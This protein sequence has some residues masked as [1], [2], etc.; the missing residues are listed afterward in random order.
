MA[1][2]ISPL[3]KNIFVDSKIADSYA[4]AETKTTCIVNGALKKYYK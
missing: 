2:T 1:Y 3:M 4:A